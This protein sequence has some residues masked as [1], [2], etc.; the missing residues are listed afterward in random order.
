MMKITYHYNNE[1]SETMRMDHD[2]TNHCNDNEYD[3]ERRW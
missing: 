2:D 3:D 1:D